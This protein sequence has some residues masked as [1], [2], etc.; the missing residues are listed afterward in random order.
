MGQNGGKAAFHTLGCKLN[1]AETSTLARELF[2]HGFERSE[3]SE[4]PDIFVIN[5]CSV[6]EN[7]NRKCR[8]LVNR[9]RR[10]APNAM[11]AVTG[12]YA[13]LKPK[14][15]AELGVDMILG[16]GEKFNL[17][18]CVLDFNKNGKP[19]IYSCE[20]E[21][22]NQ[23]SASHSQ[24]DRTRSF[25]KIQDGCDYSCSFCTIPLARGK[26][27]SD[28]IQN[29]VESAQQIGESGVQ[30]IILT[31]VNIGDFGANT[32]EDLLGLIIALDKVSTVERFRISSIEPNLLTND[33][34]KFVANSNRF[35]PHFHIPLQSGSDPILKKM[36]R[37]Y[38]SSLY[39]DRV[40]TI[41][42]KMPHCC[43]GVDVIVGFPGETDTD[44]EATYSFLS[45]LDVSYLHVFTYSERENTVA[46]DMQDVVEPIKRAERSR[47]LHML[48]EKK[49]HEFYAAHCN[50]QQRVLFE[51]TDKE[52]DINGFT[53]NYIKVVSSC[54][55]FS[56][57][58]I[59]ELTLSELGKDGVYVLKS[60]E[61]V[62][63]A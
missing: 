2:K 56:E 58:T 44:F 25:L 24:G 8:Q 45:D 18:K 61:P 1:F 3:L 55:S 6:T 30:E 14:E 7:A 26:S 52:G 11:I 48:S 40:E 57:N 28:N 12:C 53:E 37:R 22:V 27:R 34:I 9:A 31:G 51:S 17:A 15:I 23:F 62:S 19:K 60:P 33:I 39:R 42:E 35:M 50:T 16:A 4:D 46:I 21:H 59:S 36:R 29:I 10:E 5:T 47:C 38:L 13:Q 54:G 20:I 63:I 32:D 41:K 43:I 49:K